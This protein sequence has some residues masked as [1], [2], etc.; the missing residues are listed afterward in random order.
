MATNNKSAYATKKEK[1]K[2]LPKPPAR[3]REPR[4]GEGRPTKYGPHTL[5][6]TAD[7]IDNFGLC[8]DAIPSIVGL[9]LELD[10]VLSRVDVWRNDPKKKEFKDMLEKL[11]AKQ[12]RVLLAGSLLG[13]LNSNIS[14]LVLAKHGYTDKT[15]VEN[16]GVLPFTGLTIIRGKD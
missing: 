10:V 5:E 7:Y 12:Q 14:K 3:K 15:E 6:I 1:R 13:D 4:K 9:S 11:L 16:T 2:A 8:G